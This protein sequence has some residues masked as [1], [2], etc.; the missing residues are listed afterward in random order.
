MQ[1]NMDCDSGAAQFER[2]EA[3]TIKEEGEEEKRE[4]ITSEIF[5][6]LPAK[7]E[8][9]L[10]IFSRLPPK[11]VFKLK[12]VSK[13]IRD[14]TKQLNF[15][16]KHSHNYKPSTS[17]TGFF[18]QGVTCPDHDVPM[19]RVLDFIGFTPVI[20]SEHGCLPDPSLNFLKQRGDEDLVELIDSC[21]GLL[22]CSNTESIHSVT[23]YFVC[24]PLTREKVVIPD[25]CRGS[26]RVCYSLIADLNSHGYLQFKVVCLFRPKDTDLGTELLV[27]SSENGVWE[28]IEERLPELHH[29]SVMGSKVFFNGSLFWDCFEDKILVC[30]LNTKKS[31]RF[32]KLL[33]ALGA[34]LGRCLWECGNQLL[35]YCHGFPDEFPSW[36]LQINEKNEIMTWKREDGKQFENLSEDISTVNSEGWVIK[37]KAM[38]VIRFK[39]IGYNPES[40]M[41]FLWVHETIYSYVFKDRRLELV[42]EFGD[43]WWS[44]L[45]RFHSRSCVVAYKHSFGEIQTGKMEE[46]ESEAEEEDKQKITDFVELVS[47]YEASA[48]KVKPGGKNNFLCC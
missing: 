46:E 37:R 23:T 10:E 30:Q 44:Q 20:G 29:E 36:R 41:A 17:S 13:T 12:G 34:P 4:T 48:N 31:Q 16:A 26:D 11:T 47:L 15:I 43:P 9:V 40:E 1:E 24:N 19:D 18:Y 7:N 42:G 21:N 14:Q 6:K 8:I 2:D 27:F 33:E 3:I 32:H 38:P 25:P 5:T 22:L 39:I 35:C 45:W 28:E